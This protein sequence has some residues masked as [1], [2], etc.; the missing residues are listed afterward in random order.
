MSRNLQILDQNSR[1]SVVEKSSTSFIT[2]SLDTGTDGEVTVTVEGL[3]QVQFAVVV[4]ANPSYLAA[5]TEIS[6]NDLTL[7]ILNQA[8]NT[9]EA[10][11]NS[12]TQVFLIAYGR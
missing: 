7:A 8:D 3:K 5:V 2:G 12:T 9:P 6:G 4:A 1:N 11:T 10:N